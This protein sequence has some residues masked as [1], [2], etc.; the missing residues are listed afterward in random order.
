MKKICVFLLLLIL[1]FSV[2]ASGNY[3]VVSKK[4]SLVIDKEITI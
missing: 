1:P 2:L 3:T 4:Q